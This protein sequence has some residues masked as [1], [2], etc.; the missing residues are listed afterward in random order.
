MN[1]TKKKRN[2]SVWERANDVSQMRR[3]SGEVGEA[4]CFTYFLWAYVF[5]LHNAGAGLAY[6]MQ[7]KNIEILALEFGVGR[8]TWILPLAIFLRRACVRIANDWKIEEK[9]V[10]KLTNPSTV[11]FQ[12]ANDIRIGLG[13]CKSLFR[14]LHSRTM[15]TRAY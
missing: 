11:A 8:W 1:E 12:I 5:E 14:S 9:K 15:H 3:R 4:E 13:I 2:I 6:A 7:K 10:E